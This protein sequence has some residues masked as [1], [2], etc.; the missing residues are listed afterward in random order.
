MKKSKIFKKFISVLLCITMLLP[1]GLI[2]TQAADTQTVMTET[3]SADSLIGSVK[4]VTTIARAFSG[5]KEPLENAGD[6]FKYNDFG[7]AL[8]R[9]FFD[10][11]CLIA[12]AAFKAVCSIIPT[13]PSMEGYEDYKSENFY[14]GHK[15]Q[16]D[17]P[18]EGA[19][20]SLGYANGSLIPADFEAGKYF[21]GGSLQAKN[22]TAT[23]IVDDMK[24]RVTCID[25]GSGRGAVIM[26]VIDGIGI[27]STDVRRI[28]AA[29]ADFAAENNIVSINVSATHC[30]SCID[31]Q[32]FGSPFISTLLHN[33]IKNA[34]APSVDALSGRNEAF[35]NNLYKVAARCIKSAYN[36]MET[37]DLYYSTADATGYMRDKEAP[38]SLITDI[39]SLRF[40]PDNAASE[41]TYLISMADHPTQLP[42]TTNTKVSSDYIYYMEETF[43]KAGYNMIFFQG[44]GGAVSSKRIEGTMFGV[45][46]IMEELNIQN[47][48]VAKMVGMGRT[49]A[50]LVLNIDKKTEEKLAPVLNARHNEFEITEIDNWL[51]ILALKI[52]LLNNRLFKTGEGDEDMV[53]I[54]EVGYIEFGNRFAFGLMPAELYPEIE[55]G[56]AA[57]IED[58]R[59]NTPW[60]L[61]PMRELVDENIELRSICFAN[62]TVGYVLPSNDWV[63]FSDETPEDTLLSAGGDID[64]T[65]LDAFNDVVNN[66]TY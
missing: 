47:D 35:M 37:G 28:R 39:T 32:G 54:T 14:K 44:A 31:I 41:G 51:L 12:Q 33:W 30:H 61:T 40:Q 15:T 55:I 49:F 19:K 9:I 16:L 58:S 46:E 17:A 57:G 7:T 23:E 26:A 48:R 62:D 36:D 65:L 64:K 50:N 10:Y 4:S 29:V 45:A 42:H 53:F 20:W 66:W 43:N 63:F 34:N 18:A 38:I 27:S 8:K 25:D 21:M 24:I 2:G 11:L 6:V 3:E 56:G 60:D 1:M 5:L 22:L 59:N 13:P 52:E